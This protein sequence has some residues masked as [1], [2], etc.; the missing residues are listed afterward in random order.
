VDCDSLGDANLLCDG[1]AASLEEALDKVKAWQPSI[2]LIQ[3]EVFSSAVALAKY[4]Y[5]RPFAELTPVRDCSCRQ[6]YRYPLLEAFAN[7]EAPE[8]LLSVMRKRGWVKRTNRVDRLRY[9]A[10]C[11]SVHLNYIDVCPGCNGLNIS[12]AAFLHCFTC[13]HFASQDDFLRYESLVCPNCHASLRHI[14]VDY[15]RPLEHMHCVD[16]DLAFSEARVLARCL[17][18]GCEY[19]P[20]VLPVL[21]VEAYALSEEGRLA[22][23]QG[24]DGACQSP[25]ILAGTLKPSDLIE[26]ID[27]MLILSRRRGGA[28]F[29]LMGLSLISGRGL[30]APLDEDEWARRLR[31]FEERLANLL[32]SSD[33]LGRIGRNIICIVLPQTEREGGEALLEKIRMQMAESLCCRAGLDVRGE[34]LAAADM[35]VGASAEEILISISGSLQGELS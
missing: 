33:V 13:S 20:E 8:A 9:C 6:A 32:R 15:N 14:G 21:N 29:V 7:G 10:K 27:W 25:S 22:A 31:E 28:E 19:G 24:G 30:E 17:D 11:N 3:G 16:C 4:F 23:L 12:E 5:L 1:F 34:V 26:L 2:N 35:P 18:C